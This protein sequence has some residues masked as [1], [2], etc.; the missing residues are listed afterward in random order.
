MDTGNP[1]RPMDYHCPDF[2][3]HQIYRAPAGGGSKVY[4]QHVSKEVCERFV[5][6]CVRSNP[7]RLIDD[8]CVVTR[9]RMVGRPREDGGLRDVMEL[10][11]WQ[12]EGESLCEPPGGGGRP[13]G[14]CGRAR[15]QAE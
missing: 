11:V 7:S 10:V 15:S 12:L 8:I 2:D 9:E 13:C 14:G 6:L 5:K 3:A 1:Q 4:M